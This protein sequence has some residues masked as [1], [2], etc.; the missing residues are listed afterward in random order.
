VNV[1]L[2]RSTPVIESGL[3]KVSERTLYKNNGV[4][5]IYSRN[6]PH[7]P[8]RKGRSWCEVQKQERIMGIL[9]RFLQ[10]IQ[11]KKILKRKVA[12]AIVQF[13][14]FRMLFPFL[15]IQQECIR[16]M[17]SHCHG[18]R[19]LILRVRNRVRNPACQ[20]LRIR[21]GNCRQHLTR[22]HMMGVLYLTCRSSAGS[23]LEG[24]R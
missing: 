21:I 16:I 6:V 5:E 7:L 18:Q 23:L 1:F 20:M 11:G 8:G 12:A 24:Y 10:K 4:R 22:S 2:G 15:T 14:H 19:F 3:P 17:Q 13:L 9:V